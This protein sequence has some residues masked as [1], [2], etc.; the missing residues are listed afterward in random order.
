MAKLAS[1]RYLVV[2][3]LSQEDRYETDDASARELYTI[4]VSAS[5]VWTV[6]PLR[7]RQHGP[8]L[9]D[10]P[11]YAYRTAALSRLLPGVLCA[12]GDLDGP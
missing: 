6:Q 10:G 8:S 12:G 5:T 2:H 9:V 7:R 1:H 4:L 11:A 3:S